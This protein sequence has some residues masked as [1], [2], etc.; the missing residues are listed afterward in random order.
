MHVCPLREQALRGFRL[1]MFLPYVSKPWAVSGGS[2]QA[3]GKEVFPA[4]GAR[5]GAPPHPQHLSRLT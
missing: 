2:S 3:G 5:C 4:R 1:F